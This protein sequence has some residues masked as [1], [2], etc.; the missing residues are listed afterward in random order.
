MAEN[1]EKPN[2]FE[3]TIKAYLD[4][5]AATDPHFAEKYADPEKNIKKC[6]NYIINQVKKSGRH[7]FTDQE[8]YGMAVH[9]Y[10]EQDIKDVEHT[11][12]TVVV[13]HTIELTEEEK[14]AE[15]EK[16]IKQYH[17][18]V[19]SGLKKK[20]AQKKADEVLPNQMELFR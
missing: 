13:N 19:I 18:E 6:C 2:Q 14:A 11:K 1:K 4:D 9:Y 3:L 12:C 7:G 16:A 20:P 15:R 17:D 5:M 10:D 8:V